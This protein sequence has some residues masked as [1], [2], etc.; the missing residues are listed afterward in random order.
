MSCQGCLCSA[1]T[2]SNKAGVCSSL[3]VLA[4]VCR[5]GHLPFHNEGAPQWHR[6]LQV[7]AMPAAGAA[8]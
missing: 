5:T 8:R 6:G 1:S 7:Q 2:V 3:K 4:C